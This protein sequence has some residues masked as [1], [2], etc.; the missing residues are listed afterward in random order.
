LVIQSQPNHLFLPVVLEEFESPPLDTYTLR[1]MASKKNLQLVSVPYH[2]ET[3]LTASHHAFSLIWASRG[4]S[5]SPQQMTNAI[6][7]P[8]L[9]RRILRVY[10]NQ[11]KIPKRP[12]CKQRIKSISMHGLVSPA[13]DVIYRKMTLD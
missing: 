13:W 5:K 6:H 7:M 1:P 12:V 8:D 9:L 4:G 10:A 11:R 3:T 2:A